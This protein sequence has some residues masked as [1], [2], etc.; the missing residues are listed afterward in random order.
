MTTTE[1][2][3]SEVKGFKTNKI[4]CMDGRKKKSAHDIQNNVLFGV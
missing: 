3:T 1:Q 4:L 2:I